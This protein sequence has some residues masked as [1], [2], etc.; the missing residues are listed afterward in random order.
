MS[1][2]TLY[3]TRSVILIVNLCRSGKIDV[4]KLPVQS[5]S[6][7][8]ASTLSTYK[9]VLMNK[10]VNL[11]A[12]HR[13]YFSCTSGRYEFD[14]WTCCPVKH[15]VLLQ[16]SRPGVIV[17]ATTTWRLWRIL[18][19]EQ[20]F[21]AQGWT[22]EAED[23]YRFCGKLSFRFEGIPASRGQTLGKSKLRGYFLLINMG[24]FHLNYFVSCRGSYSWSK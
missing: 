6:I 11:L 12:P 8:D 22:E 14:L 13:N 23:E 7:S 10:Q 4:P 15:T 17:E 16:V 5:L 2:C 24:S 20:I 1:S 18:P 3:V 21:G 9:I 19:H